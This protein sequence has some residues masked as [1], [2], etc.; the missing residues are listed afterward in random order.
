MDGDEEEG[1]SKDKPEPK[2]KEIEDIGELRQVHLFEKAMGCGMGG[3]CT[4]AERY[5]AFKKLLDACSKT[6]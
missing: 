3:S 4:V 2:E 5:S 1:K 6:N